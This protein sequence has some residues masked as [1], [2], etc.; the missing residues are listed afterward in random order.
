M[1]GPYAWYCHISR[2]LQELGY[3]KSRADPF[4]FFLRD[5]SDNSIEGI[6]GPAT[7]D[8]VAEVATAKTCSQSYQVGK[9]TTGQGKFT[10][11]N[12]VPEKMAQ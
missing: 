3:E 10:G 12:I 7:D 4:L 5:P 9:F 8:M 2:I 11:K 6:V 1:D